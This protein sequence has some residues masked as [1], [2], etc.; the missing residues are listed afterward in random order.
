MN[1]SQKWLAFAGLAALGW[2]VY[3]LSPILTPFV[4]G[5]LLAY[6][7]DPLADRLESLGMKRTPAVVV[8]FAA[9]LLVLA[10]AV[11]VL[12]PLLEHQMDRLVQNLPAYAAW[13]KN[14]ALPLLRNR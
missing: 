13:I 1:D 9:I 8:V 14:K 7:T 12:V 10:L 4:A 3:L 6:L 2:L 11:L 5:A